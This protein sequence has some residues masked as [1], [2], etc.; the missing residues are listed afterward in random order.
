MMTPPHRSTSYSVYIMRHEDEPQKK[1]GT[2]WD[3]WTYTDGITHKLEEI[4]GNVSSRSWYSCLYVVFR[5]A[6]CSL[7]GLGTIALN[8]SPLSSTEE[9]AIS[10]EACSAC[11]CAS[12]PYRFE[13]VP[14]EQS[15]IH[16]TLCSSSSSAHCFF[17][18]VILTRTSSNSLPTVLLLL[19]F[20]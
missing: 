4:S 14:E 20:Q 5:F 9:P 16:S 1:P 3:L 6:I 15:S 13:E 18:S 11:Y 8:D 7:L 2:D 17:H 10:C 19:I 12:L